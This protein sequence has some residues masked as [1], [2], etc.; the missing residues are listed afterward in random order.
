MYFE[1]WE[2]LGLLVSENEI[3]NARKQLCIYTPLAYVKVQDMQY[4]RY[5]IEY[6]LVT[7]WYDIVIYIDKCD[8]SSKWIKKSL[9]Q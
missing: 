2:I 7:W 4:T 9:I 3:R 8:A 5:T 1:W 6:R